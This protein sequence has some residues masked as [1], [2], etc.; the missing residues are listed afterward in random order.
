MSISIACIGLGNM[1]YPIAKN[2]ITSDKGFKVKLYNRS[3]EKIKDLVSL[4][5]EAVATIA[6]AVASADI[7]ITMVS[8]D[9]ALNQITQEILPALKK[10]SIHL[11]MSTIKAETSQQLAE[12][13]A[14]RGA[15]YLASPVM[16]RPP[17]AAARQL[18]ILLSGDESAKEKVKPVLEA[19]SQRTFDFGNDP[20]IAH[21]VKVIMNFMIFTTVELL[22]EVMLMAEKTGIDKNILLDTMLNT[23]YGAPV[24]KIYGAL[25]AKEEDNPNGFAVHLANKD[26]RLAQETAAA[27]GASLPLAELI[28]THFES[29]IAA[30]GGK[31]DLPMLVSHLREQA[32]VNFVR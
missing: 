9:T 31:K 28:R 3:P 26:L 4:G 23:I 7:I 2:I 14:L 18:F 8:D 10:G 21:T 1:G 15:V 6:D 20:A 24:F 32:E 16:G 27:A 11:S 25:V 13:H 17:A 5:G 29:M 12:K 22:S 19:V 30:G